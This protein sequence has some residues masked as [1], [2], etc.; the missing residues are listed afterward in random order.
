[1]VVSQYKLTNYVN[2]VIA[3]TDAFVTCNK[4][5]RDNQFPCG[6]IKELIQDI[7]GSCDSDGT[8]HEGLVNCCSTNNFNEK[9]HLLKEKW[10]YSE[11]VAFSDCKQH[12]HRFHKWFMEHKAAVFCD[13]ILRPLREDVG[14]GIPPRSFYTNDNKSANA[15]LKECVVYKQKWPIFDNKLKKY[16]DNIQV[17]MEKAIMGC[18]QYH[19]KPQ[20]KFL[21]VAEDTWF[22]MRTKQRL[23]YINKFITYHV[24]SPVTTSFSA[25]KEN[26][27][28]SDTIV[29]GNFNSNS[30][31]ISMSH[32]EAFANTRVP[33]NAA[34][35]IWK[36]AAML[37]GEENSIV[38]APGCGPKDTY[39]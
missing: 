33:H 27:K 35:G 10:D 15:L 31:N 25:V 28:Q 8:V 32:E 11:Q 34:E 12:T 14:L 37:I 6:V 36:K 9:L 18:G 5:I 23:K 4:N 13:H 30:D 38:L 39:M 7:F 22:K 16:V 29:Y 26:D 20:Y 1:M 21:G 17:E 3:C 2:S 24:R 19:L